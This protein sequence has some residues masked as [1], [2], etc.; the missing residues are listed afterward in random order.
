[1][2]EGDGWSVG[3]S[4]LIPGETYHYRAKATGSSGAIVYGEDVTFTLAAYPSAPSSRVSSLVHRW[5]PG[6][7]NLEIVLGGFNSNYGIP[8][9]MKK[10]SPAIQTYT[11]PNYSDP[12]YTLIA[13]GLEGF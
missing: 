13:T 6:N 12:Y 2:S 3:L 8:I 1:V 5:S 11:P 9:V 7:Y 4:D 10:P